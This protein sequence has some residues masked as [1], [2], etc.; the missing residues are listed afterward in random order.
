MFVI[1]KK[2]FIYNIAIKLKIFNNRVNV[3]L[4]RE[5]K[6]ILSTDQFLMKEAY[7]SYPELFLTLQRR[8]T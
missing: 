2:K 8:E 3:W 6:Y 5:C 1:I 4:Y 7:T